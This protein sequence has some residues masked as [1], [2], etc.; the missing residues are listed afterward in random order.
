M[1]KRMKKILSLILAVSMTIPFLTA[2]SSTADDGTKGT[3]NESAQVTEDEKKTIKIWYWEDNDGSYAD[4]Y[5]TWSEKYPNTKLELEAIPWNSYHDML[6]AAAASGDMPDVYKI[7]PSWIPELRS[8]GAITEL[9]SYI[10]E[11]EGKD[12][13]PDSMWQSAKAE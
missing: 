8:L 2:C 7:Q 6:L 13:I 11:W 4:A 9:N 3:S 5:A 1:K 10:D 12:T